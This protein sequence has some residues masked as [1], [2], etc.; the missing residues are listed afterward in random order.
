MKKSVVMIVLLGVSVAAQAQFFTTVPGPDATDIACRRFLAETA[1][2]CGDTQKMINQMNSTGDLAKALLVNCT[3]YSI[4]AFYIAPCSHGGSLGCNQLNGIVGGSSAVSVVVGAF[5]VRYDIRIV[6]TDGR[7]L[8]FRNH[9]I[10]P[11]TSNIVLTQ[12][13]ANNYSITN[14]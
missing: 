5:D 7:T 4:R 12:T 8:D 14:K 6:F 11:G 3:P 2:L 1:Q 10:G 9:Y 13:G